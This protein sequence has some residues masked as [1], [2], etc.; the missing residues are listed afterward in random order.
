MNIIA[1]K[2]IN[3]PGPSAVGR[4]FML[5]K[6][7]ENKERLEQELQRV[8]NLKVATKTTDRTARSVELT[9]K[10]ISEEEFT[11]LMNQDKIFA[12]Y[13]LESNGKRYG[14]E[15]DAFTGEDDDILL[16]DASVYQ[17]LDLKEKLGDALYSVAVVGSRDYREANI[18]D[19]I[20]AGKSSESEDEIQTRLNLGDAH[21]VL[22]VLMAKESF[23][24]LVDKKFH[25][26]VE[27][28]ISS[29][30][31]NEESRAFIKEFSRSDNVL[32]LLERII[33]SDMQAVDEVFIRG[34]EDHLPF[35]EDFDGSNLQKKLHSF[36]GNA[37][38]DAA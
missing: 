37:L 21:V 10:S 24:D 20:K 36:F 30:G 7:L 33:H 38:K 6:L 8:I 14:Y 35:G 18:R 19:R 4:D 11:E 34:T 22:L 25:E 3:F 32:Q 5:E 12:A 29:R 27:L 17:T 1:K 2:I 13:V 16:S 9:K 28:F 31:Q 15:P 23:A 26:A